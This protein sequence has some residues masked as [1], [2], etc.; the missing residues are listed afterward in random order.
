MERSVEIRVK[1]ALDPLPVIQL[2]RQNLAL[3][4]ASIDEA[5][6]HKTS[7]P[8][9]TLRMGDPDAVGPKTITLLDSLGRLQV[10][11]ELL[12]EG[13]PQSRQF[14]HYWLAAMHEISEPSIEALE[15][16]RSEDSDQFQIMLEM[17]KAGDGFEVDEVTLVWVEEQLR[18]LD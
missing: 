13:Q 4:T 14:L 1:E 3:S 2:F 8:V 9:G 5:I 6:R 17:I 15:A 18:G 10:K 11:Y 7:L 12:L 16:L